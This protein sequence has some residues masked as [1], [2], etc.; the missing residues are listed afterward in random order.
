[1]RSTSIC[2]LSTFPEHFTTAFCPTFTLAV[3]STRLVPPG[4]IGSGTFTFSG[5]AIT[6]V[7]L[8]M[9]SDP[10]TRSSRL[11]SSSAAASSAVVRSMRSPSLTI[12]FGTLAWMPL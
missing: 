5:S 7:P 1:M 4:P 9:A 6:L 3:R 12:T 11:R 10:A 8:A 2:E